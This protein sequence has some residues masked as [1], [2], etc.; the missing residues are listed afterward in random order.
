MYTDGQ[1]SGE[2]YWVT[3]LAGAGK[4]TIA[5]ALQ[6]RLRQSG[7]AVVLLDGD[8][9]RA[10]LGDRYGHSVEERRYLAGCYGRLCQTLAAQG[11]DVVCATVSMF[12]S[13]RE[14]NRTAIAH[15]H[16]IY[17][18]APRPDLEA[19]RSFYRDAPAADV[20]GLC[21][22]YELPDNPDLIIA[23]DGGRTPDELAEL[24]LGSRRN[25]LTTT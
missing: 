13:V 17:V 21:P 9:L 16:E 8:A 15:Y 18:T 19:R 23:N 1:D 12:H 4:T 22:L 3:G 6:R 11:T 20:V 5:T 14:R 10:V 24:I 25:L 7:R 2:V